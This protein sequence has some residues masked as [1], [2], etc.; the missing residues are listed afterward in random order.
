MIK[1][2]IPHTLSCGEDGAF[3]KN[4]ILYHRTKFESKRN[5]CLGIY[6][7]FGEVGA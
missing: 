1:K 4:K 7:E 2:M 5:G 3:P 6:S